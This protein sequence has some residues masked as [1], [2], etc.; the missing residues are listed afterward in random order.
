MTKKKSLYLIDG[1]SYAFRAFHALSPLTTSSGQVVNA[2]Y[3]FTR[4]LMRLLKERDPDY[5]AVTFDTPGPTFRHEAYEAY[6]A[7][8]EE[9]PETFREQLHLIKEVIDA[10]RIPTFEKEGYEADDILA[11]LSKKAQS[12]GLEVFIISSDKDTFQLVSDDIKVIDPFKEF[13]IYDR[14][15]V[16]ERFGVYPEALIE[17][18]ALMGD[19]IDNVP[20]VP[21]VGPKTASQLIKQFGS[22]DALFKNL[23]R[24]ERPKLKEALAAHKEQAFLS[25][26]LV[27][28]DANMPLKVDFEECR[29]TGY[30]EERLVKLFETLEFRSL[31]KEIKQD[32]TVKSIE[33]KEASYHIV[34]S[35][36]ALDSLIEAVK[37]ASCMVIDLETTNK[38][39]MLASLVGIAIAITP[40]EAFYIPVNH[41]PETS[42]AQDTLP[43]DSPK[44]SDLL[45]KR[46]VLKR[47]KP[48]LEDEGVK[49]IGQN[50][51][52]EII[53]L[54]Q[55]GIEVKGISFDTMVASYLLN[56]SKAQHNLDEIAM[57]YLGYQKIPT[58]S[59]I[60][61]TLTMDQVEVE[62][63]ANYA[64]EDADITLRL[65]G[66]LMPLLK[67]KQLDELFF[68][69]EMALIP[70]L[71]RM[72]E[73]G[74]RLDLKVFKE[75]DSEL[76]KSL[77]VLQAQIYQMA[78][79][80]FNINS[81]Q[82]LSHILYEKLKLPRGKKL[83]SQYSTDVRALERLAS[84]E[85][86]LPQK[87]LE[88]RT[89]AKLK[90]TYVDALPALIN[91]RTKKVHTSYNQTVTAT[92]RLS[93]SNPNLQN[94]PIRSEL[95]RQLRRAF[96]PT[97]E[98]YLF[99]GAD[100]S[101][102][103]LRLLAHLSQ[104]DTLMMAFEEGKDIHA[105]TA[106][107]IFGVPL[108]DVT[109]EMRRRAKAVN[110]GI[111]Y[112]MSAY[113]LSQGLGIST[114]E[115]Q[116]FI[117][118]YFAIHPK[119]KSY[120]DGL[121]EEARQ[122]GFVTT[123]LN[124]RRYIPD[125]NNPKAPLRSLAERTAVNTP[126]Q[127]S[128]ADFIKLAMIKLDRALSSNFREGWIV[129]QV[130]DELLI[131]V[132]REEVKEAKQLVKEVMEKAYPLSVPNKVDI[133]HGENWLEA[134]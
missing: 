64:C 25:K 37:K 41:S 117:D 35:M 66:E 53:V 19:P 115:A 68:Q 33:D 61:K 4:M 78:G 111:I 95:G 10:F 131:E 97:S 57:E 3:G 69:V 94:I 13:F 22:M 39:P 21:G 72:E 48:I 44:S 55:E 120:L 2:V 101:Q 110:F 16:K 124:R 38:E 52:Y 92:G 1:H 18:M 12:E 32:T 73:R 85:H 89:L 17:V 31:I 91:R 123:I 28:L 51:K 103:E 86:E 99:I 109:F 6:K 76:I 34:S 100:Y 75:L 114:E 127:G 121:V 24:V 83:K 40:K 50:I 102:I 125:I 5:L 47:L 128:A 105:Q 15:K 130:H 82:Q 14:E 27:K 71:A 46:E 67:E 54:S 80:E 129:L 113:G 23:D 87:L 112:G 59:L 36:E 81:P 88:Y 104:D 132:K 7:Q 58:S 98:E 56:P 93:S 70:V 74:I 29:Y 65:Q 20:G 9:A 79:E 106:S 77:S 90:S 49:K 84:L 60:G 30:D 62:K 8:R 96:I 126:I 118:Q 133:N 116:A 119:V 45:P 63:V 11:S 26:D 134:H 108:E 107:V 122:R 42:Q 43:F